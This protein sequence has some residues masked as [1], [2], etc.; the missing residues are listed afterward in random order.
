MIADPF[1]DQ[2]KALAQRGDA[3]ALTEIARHEAR[4]LGGGDAPAELVHIMSIAANTTD[5]GT[6]AACA[7]KLHEARTTRGAGSEW[8]TQEAL[9]EIA[10]REMVATTQSA[11]NGMGAPIPFD[12]GGAASSLF[13]Q[14]VQKVTIKTNVTPEMSY[15]AGAPGEPPIVTNETGGPGEFLLKKVQPKIEMET[16]MG[17]VDMAPYGEPQ[18]GKWFWPVAIASVVV[19]GAGLYF[20]IRGIHATFWRRK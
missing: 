16:P 11:A 9:D 5:A 8:N 2:V 1:Y 14:T 13:G 3:Q 15:E 12:L 6:L 17:R 10:Q 4:L 7:M 19:G 18:S 20:L